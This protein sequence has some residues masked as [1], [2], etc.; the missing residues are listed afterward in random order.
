MVGLLGLAFQAHAA[1]MPTPQISIGVG[2]DVRNVTP[3][4]ITEVDM[5][6]YSVWDLTKLP[7]M[8]NGSLVTINKIELDPDPS[9]TANYTVLNSSGVTQTYN[10]SVI[11]PVS[12]AFGSSTQSGSIGMTVTNDGNG[13][14]TVQS[15]GANA[16]Y[17]ALID[18]VPVHTLMN[19]PFTFTVPLANDS[20]S[21]PSDKFGIP[22]QVP[23][24]G[25]TTNIAINLQFTL[26]PGDQ[27]GITSIFVVNPVPEPASLSLVG[28][29]LATL[30]RRRR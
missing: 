14:A 12:P 26:T 6:G 4:T 27:V 28:L 21:P 8:Q 17:T 18:G 5:G 2:N 13:G 11:M 9:V 10:F 30:A 15:V 20:L 22:V 7:W 16:V 3:S 1:L 29:G 19:S 24:G 25:V 23:G